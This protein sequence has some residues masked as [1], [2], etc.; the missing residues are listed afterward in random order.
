MKNNIIYFVIILGL[1]ALNTR[2]LFKEKKETI[3]QDKE[4]SL[5]S[6]YENKFFVEKEHENLKLDENLKLV[7]IEGD[8]VLAKDV[9]N[10]HKIVFRYSMLNCGSCINAEYNI[11]E[12]NNS[13]IDNQICIIAY[14]DRVSD[15]I[16]DY[17]K[18]EQIELNN[19]SVYLLPN[20]ELGIPMDR[21]NTPYYFQINQDLVINNFFVP[22][23]EIPELSDN[24][25]KYAL[26]N[27]TE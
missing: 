20:D 19:I 18:L 25:L 21:N 5:K 26:K 4:L 11:L 17:K 14:Y 24:Y 10:K 27:F 9:F 13:L 23:K 1:F 6:F 16:I 3:Y 8:T 2:L 15:L 7:T 12:T 22:A